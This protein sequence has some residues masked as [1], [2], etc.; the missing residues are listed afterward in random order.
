MSNRNFQLVPDV[1]HSYDLSGNAF[2]LYS[3]LVSKIGYGNMRVIPNLTASSWLGKKDAGAGRT[4]LREL[5]DKHLIRIIHEHVYIRDNGSKRPSTYQ[6][7]ELLD[8]WDFNNRM[9]FSTREHYDAKVPSVPKVNPAD[10][11]PR[12]QVGSIAREL[13]NL[14]DHDWRSGVIEISIADNGKIKVIQ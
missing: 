3:I 13:D 10:I 12:G 1:I 11:A 4:Y 2:K 9:G 8:L 5:A 14:L 6:H 7:I